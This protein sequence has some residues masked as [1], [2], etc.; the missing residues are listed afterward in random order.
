MLRNGDQEK[1]VGR[2]EE[3]S[4]NAWP[5]LQTSLYDGWI[6]RFADGYT[7]RA[8]S[9]SPLYPSAQPPAEKV[10][11]VEKL[12]RDRHLQVVFKMTANSYPEGL[13]DFLAARGY[14]AEGH[15]SV[16]LLDLHDEPRSSSCEI[17]HELTDEWFES[18]CRLSQLAPKYQ[19]AARQLLQRIIPRT[20]FAFLRDGGEIIAGGLGVVERDYIG[21]F[22]IVT[23]TRCRRQGYGQQIVQGLLKW[24]KE[25]RAQQAYLQ[26]TKKNEPA[27][28]LYSKLD[29]REEYQYWYRVKV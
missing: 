20:G 28:A 24:G 25:Q 27:L 26:V 2:I 8:N 10:I 14:P 11:E 4:L 22:D 13:D 12:Y 18:F 7:R 9:I 21:L 16:Q 3:L 6:L 5:A 17:N 1:M 29:F 23:E 15:T 19:S